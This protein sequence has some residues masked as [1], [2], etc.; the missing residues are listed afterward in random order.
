MHTHTHT[1]N[2]RTFI[3]NRG[4]TKT[5]C[6]DPPMPI[7]SKSSSRRVA[8][9]YHKHCGA[10]F[11]VRSSLGQ[12]GHTTQARTPASQPKWGVR[13]LATATPPIN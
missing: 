3:V 2:T 12:M 1:H 8:R 6:K 9:C 4:R 11:V 7:A 5:S 10:A 13:Y